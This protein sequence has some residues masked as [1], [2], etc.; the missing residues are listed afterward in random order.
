MS[1][2]YI[3]LIFGAVF[4]IYCINTFASIFS[5]RKNISK[6]NLSVII[7]VISLF[8]IMHLHYLTA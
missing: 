8:H 5:K 6:L 7:T 4:E 1:V 3:S 2:K